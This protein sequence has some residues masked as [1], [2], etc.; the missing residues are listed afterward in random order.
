[1]TLTK[2]VLLSFLLACSL[3]A[4]SAC[5]DDPKQQV[6]EEEDP[7]DE[8][9]EEDFEDEDD[10]TGLLDASTKKPDAGKRDAGRDAGDA[11]RSDGGGRDSGIRGID[12]GVDE[13]GGDNGGTGPSVVDSGRTEEPVVFD[14]NCIAIPINATVALEG[15]CLN[16]K[17]GA[18]GRNLGFPGLSTACRTY[19]YLANG[20]NGLINVAALPKQ[21]ATCGA[22]AST[23]P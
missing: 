2:R 5:S 21:A 18:T 23:S 15:C 1:M 16:G 20:F 13:V 4:A 19:E 22:G 14:D 6:I 17:C 11:G 9:E 8:E 7:E 10:S 12:S 3:G